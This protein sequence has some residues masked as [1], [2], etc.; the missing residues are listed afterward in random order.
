MRYIGPAGVA[1][2]GI[3]FLLTSGCAAK[4]DDTRAQELYGNARKIEADPAPVSAADARERMK[5]ARDLY[6]QAL[7]QHP[8]PAL[9]G[10]IHAGIANTSYWMDDYTTAAAE[11]SKAYPLLTEPN[12]KSYA[13]Y[14][15]GLCQ[16]RLG[17][18]ESADQTFDEVERQFPNTDAAAKAKTRQGAR[19]FTVQLATFANSGTA[20][21]AV[22]D[23][24]KKGVTATRT[25]DNAGH[26]VVSVGPIPT[27]AQAV[28]VKT[29]FASAYP[30][31]VIVP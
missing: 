5:S 2:A 10:N 27:Y 13:L 19:A 20:D 7:D 30:S 23:L 8:T 11:W 1:F 21:N 25:Y 6:Y 17:K 4:P 31:A 18:F 24:R 12:D 29:Q 22:N 14:R 15:V 9:E 3:V 28:S 26:T 16:Q